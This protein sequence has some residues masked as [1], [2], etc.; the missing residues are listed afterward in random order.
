[1]MNGGSGGAVTQAISMPRLEGGEEVEGRGLGSARVCLNGMGCAGLS[2]HSRRVAR[3]SP[4]PYHAYGVGP[5]AFVV[6]PLCLDLAEG[7]TPLRMP[8]IGCISLGI[9][10]VMNHVSAKK[11]EKKGTKEKK[12]G[13][14]K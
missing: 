6:A 9:S 5:Q 13:I 3:C 2:S 8:E 10:L 4:L 7:E 14:M 11:K 12:K 1:M